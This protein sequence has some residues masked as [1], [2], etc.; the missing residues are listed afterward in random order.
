MTTYELSMPTC[1][2]LAEIGMPKITQ[3]SLALTYAMAL[4]SSADT[5]WGMV[6]KAIIERW[7]FA[8]LERVKRLAW[9]Y[10]EHGT[11]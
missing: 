8:G 1:T 5:D 7:S 11:P 2:L 10:V 6:N 9:K 4:A 3:K